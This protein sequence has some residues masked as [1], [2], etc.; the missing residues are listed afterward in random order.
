MPMK[1]LVMLGLIRLSAADLPKPELMMD[2]VN[3]RYVLRW[4]Y[5]TTANFTAQW[6]FSHSLSYRGVCFGVEA[7]CDYSAHLDYSG[8]FVLRVRAEAEG[9][10]SDWAI[11]EFCPDVDAALG[12]PSELVVEAGDSMVTV[13]F[14]EPM[15]E[16]GEPMSSVL[17]RNSPEAAMA[18]RL[19]FR[20]EDAP[21]QWQEKTL[22]TTLHTLSLPAHTRYCLKVQAFSEAFGKTSG[23]TPE[24][25]TTTLGSSLLWR[26]L[27]P[28]LLLLVVLGGLGFL[29]T[30]RRWRQF[31]PS[32][33][34]SSMMMDSKSHQPLLVP[35][36]TSC[37]VTAVVAMPTAEQAVS[38][39]PAL[40][41]TPGPETGGCHC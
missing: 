36:E 33:L 1:L 5:S 3:T 9:Q 10:M 14:K 23:Y 4:N 12:T 25:C 24:Q 28:L 26:V 39:G 35:R 8:L 11:R 40:A 13:S 37:A 30:R 27:L 20:A 19:S 17:S 22:N 41:P 7:H 6:A 2:A 15:A 32:A 18:F 16:S 34:P 31:L 38:D 29:W 21:S